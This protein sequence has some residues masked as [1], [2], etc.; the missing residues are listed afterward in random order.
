MKARF[1][2]FVIIL[3]TIF[4]GMS[5]TG[6]QSPELGSIANFVLFTS[7]GALVNTGISHVNGDIGTDVGAI[8]GF[9]PPTV[10]Y[11][12]IES[13]NAATMQAKIDL[14]VAYQQ[15]FN[16]ASTST[17]HDAVFGGGETL[18]AGVYS[19]AAAGSL[20]GNL[21]LNAQGNPN[22]IFIFKF[23]GAFTTGAGSS[24]TLINGAQAT[25]VYWIAEG[26]ISMAASTAMKGTL[27]AN[28][29][30]ISLG[31]GGNLV[32]RMLSTIGEA[33]IYASR[34][35]LT[36]FPFLNPG[37][38]PNLGTVANFAIFTSGGAID[39]TS[40]SNITGDIGT[41]VGAIT[42]FDPPSVVNGSFEI[43]NAATAQATIDLD[44]AYVQL[45]FTPPTS[46][47]HAAV[48]GLGETLT[49]GVYSI[50]AAGS[51]DGNLV[52]DGQGNPNAVF[53]FKFGGALTTG[54]GA[55]VTLINGASASNIFWISE[56]AISMAATTIMKGRMIANN[57]AI[58]MGVG[59]NLEGNMWSTLGAASVY[60]DV[61]NIP[62]SVASFPIRLY[63]FS[64]LC[65]RQQV[66]LSWMTISEINNDFFSVERSGV[67][68]NWEQVGTVGGNGT[69]F[70]LHHYTL[71]DL[72]PS[73][74]IS[75]YRLKQTD[76]NGHVEYSKTIS[77]KNC[78]NHLPAL[79][80]YPNPSDGYFQLKLYGNLNPPESI[81][82]Y[83]AQGQKIYEDDG[84]LLKF[85]ISNRP[86]GFYYMN[87]YWNSKAVVLKL[88]L[89]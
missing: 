82:I 57:G 77:V 87:V 14:Q 46:T 41:E 85:D 86:A 88:I 17:D 27:I 79:V 3:L 89:K 35:S 80:V 1:E 65:K 55:T 16:T 12:N 37:E 49:P 34:I 68:R 31:A 10:V 13:S 28:N 29:G 23:G 78:G 58:S 39:N 33:S 36:P 32:G 20:A 48:F 15:L 56:G 40:T 75:F 5:T 47:E 38:T 50:A 6:A 44:A 9:G 67:D 51:V 43:D 8:T 66:V 54:A 26:A 42:G 81:E 22:A 61:I 62:G 84:Y 18:L 52:L 7:E 64:G 2:I 21:I 11:G 19:I 83:N 60:E 72:R 76:F 74:E 45:Y 71:T 25:N 53:I 59:G 70:D 4:T 30:A 69:T 24:V 73:S 63:S